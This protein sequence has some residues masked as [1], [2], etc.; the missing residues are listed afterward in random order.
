MSLWAARDFK[1]GDAIAAYMGDRVGEAR[2]EKGEKELKKL[3]DE[4]K[5]EHVMEI[6]GQYVDERTHI[7]GAQYMNMR[8]KG[9]PGQPNNVEIKGGGT[10]RV[11]VVRGVRKG[12]ELRLDYGPEYWET[13]ARK[14]KLK[15]ILKE[16]RRTTRKKNEG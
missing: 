15:E 7:G 14:E 16:H 4:G 8:L 6:E 2:T 11:K 12:E 5:G 3:T 10:L 13:D 1:D 9:I